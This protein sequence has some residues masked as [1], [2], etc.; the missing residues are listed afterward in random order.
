MPS[1]SVVLILTLALGLAGCGDFAE[2]S[3]TLDMTTVD[4]RGGAVTFQALTVDV[5]AQ[6]LA[7][8]VPLR[9]T[10]VAAA[11]ALGDGYHLEPDGQRFAV[12]VTVTFVLD[13]LA[14][15]PA[16]ELFLADFTHHPPQPLH[17]LHSDAHAIAGITSATG[18]FALLRCPGGVCPH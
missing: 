10:T 7:Q 8:T 12:P 16:G 11:G 4:T 3:N 15:P 18:T 9:V 17:N 13:G 14:L 6:A 1:R 5:P 2:S